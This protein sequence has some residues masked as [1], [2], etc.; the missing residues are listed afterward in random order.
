MLSKKLFGFKR[1]HRSSQNT[2]TNV[3]WK[4]VIYR[5]K[6]N[7]EEELLEIASGLHKNLT[8]TIERE[9]DTTLPFLDMKIYRQDRKLSSACY[10][11]PTEA[12][13]IM[14]F[15]ACDPTRYKRKV[16]EGMVYPIHNA[17]SNWALFSQGIT[18]AK[19]WEQ[20]SYPPS[21]YNS[22]F[23]SVIEKILSAKQ[24]EKT[25][26][27]DNVQKSAKKERATIFLEYRI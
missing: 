14:S 1:H 19:K 10:C 3:F 16:I 7:E 9:E 2:S 26:N 13:L 6:L 18:E 8:F 17:T 24:L 12:G 22:V 4:Q 5:V 11:K 21:F 27:S 15:H 23:G 25:Q 20:N